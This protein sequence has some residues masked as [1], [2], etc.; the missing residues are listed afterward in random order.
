MTEGYALLKSNPAEAKKR[1][2]KAA[3]IDSTNFYVQRQLGFIYL[4]EQDYPRSL[5]R[6]QAAERLSSTDVV[7]LQIAYVLNQMGKKDESKAILA[8]LKYS[9]SA[10]IRTQAELQEE[11]AGRAAASL[12]SWPRLYSEI[13]YDTRWQSTFFNINF[14][15]GEYLGKSRQFGLYGVA[16][17]A[18]DTKSSGGAVPTIISDNSL[19]LG[20]GLRINALKGLVIE[21]QE[22]IAYH[23]VEPPS[24]PR[25]ENDFRVVGVYGN[26]LYAP[27]ELHS[28]VKFPFRPYLDFY[29]SVGYYNRYHNSIG[30]FQLRPGFRAVEV[31]RTV[32][33]AYAFGKVT[34]DTGHEFY[35][36][37][38][39]TGAG[40]RVTPNVYF[41]LHLVGEYIHGTYLD[42][43]PESTAQREALYPHTYDGFRFMVILDTTF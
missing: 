23:L 11:A 16:A 31:S 14:Q 9:E 35:N 1:F 20:G 25:V 38:F 13:F 41:G 10:Y 7:R 39:E 2:L 29:S 3:E 37:V 36:N 26:G 30:F 8:E 19:I 33:D 18:T 42:V 43:S 27:F 24:A 12:K 34:L 15:I 32:A 4:Q 5:Q 17:V 21:V 22:G 40:L 6:F 28:N